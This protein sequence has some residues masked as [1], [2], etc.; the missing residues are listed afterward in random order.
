MPQSHF[1]AFSK[2]SF[3]RPDCT[4]CGARMR[5][6]RIEPAQPDHDL[7]TFE[8]PVCQHSESIAVKYK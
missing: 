1:L 4:E 8:C 5:L 3:D 2:R 7:R 6:A